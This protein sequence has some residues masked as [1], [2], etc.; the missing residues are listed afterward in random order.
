MHPFLV[1]V[2]VGH[3]VGSESRRLLQVAAFLQILKSSW[4]LAG[5][6]PLHRT[7]K[8]RGLLCATSHKE[9][10]QFYSPAASD[11]ASSGIRLTPSG[12][13]YASFMANKISRKP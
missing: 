12:I 8:E 11:I 7:Q 4:Q 9:V 1:P 2:V 5:S 13:R 10:A 3:R 6:P